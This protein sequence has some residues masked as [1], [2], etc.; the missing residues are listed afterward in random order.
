MH[1]G[2]RDEDGRVCLGER[3]E[4]DYYTLFTKRFQKF[5]YEYKYN[6]CTSVTIYKKLSEMF[7]KFIT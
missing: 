5:N 1:G 7:H 3:E 4:D 6:L 2:V